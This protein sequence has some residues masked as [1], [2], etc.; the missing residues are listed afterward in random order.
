[1]K[2]LNISRNNLDTLSEIGCLANLVELNASDNNLND[3]KEMSILLNFWPK[4]K[5]FSLSGNPIC[6]KNKYRERIIVLAPNLEYLDEKE[7]KEISK[8]FLQNWKISKEISQ[9][10]KTLKQ[11]TLEATHVFSSTF[12]FDIYDSVKSI[13]QVSIGN[14]R[15][16]VFQ[17]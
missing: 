8:Q 3:M 2:I 9:Q 10:N 15:S 12:A 6:F 5:R 16:F 4:L 7:I 14:L 13:F 17:F 1:M 11:E